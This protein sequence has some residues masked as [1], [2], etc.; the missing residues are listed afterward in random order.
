MTSQET[1]NKI[2]PT[3]HKIKEMIEMFIESDNQKVFKHQ[4]ARD[5]MAVYTEFA[6]KR[7]KEVDHSIDVR[8]E[9]DVIV[10]FNKFIKKWC[11]GN[12]AHLIDDDEQD[13]Q[14]MR[15]KIL[16]LLPIKEENK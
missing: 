11:G 7:E 6:E 14:F 4:F 16:E 3:L 8:Y 10:A 2:D 9:P 1:Q 12:Y 5:L 15:E 13:G